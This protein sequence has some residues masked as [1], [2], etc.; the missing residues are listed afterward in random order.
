MVTKS[1]QGYTCRQPWSVLHPTGDVTTLAEALDVRFD[2]FYLGEAVRTRV[3]FEKCE[4]GYLLE[5]EGPQDG[6]VFDRE[7]EYVVV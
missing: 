1:C 5:S 3:G 4:L 2:G 6:A 7:R